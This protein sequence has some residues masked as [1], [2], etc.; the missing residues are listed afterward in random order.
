MVCLRTQSNELTEEAVQHGDKI[1]SLEEII[2]LEIVSQLY[3]AGLGGIYER[4][5]ISDGARTILCYKK[6]IAFTVGDAFCKFCSK[7]LEVSC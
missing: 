3:T 5:N 6:N 2:A 7:C 1:D 4:W